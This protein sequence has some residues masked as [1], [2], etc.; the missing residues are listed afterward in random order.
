MVLCQRIGGLAGCAQ[1]H[2]E[3]PIAYHISHL[4]F[5][6]YY[7]L[8]FILTMVVIT[9]IIER[10]EH[11]GGER[12]EYGIPQGT[13]MQGL[14]PFS[15]A[16]YSLGQKRIQP[17]TVWSLCVAQIKASQTWYSGLC[18]FF[19]Q[20]NKNKSGKM[21]GLPLPRESFCPFSDWWDKWLLRGVSGAQASPV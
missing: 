9:T 19:I 15:P 13:G 4:R 14:C 11:E 17:Y 21:K 8:F 12:C 3:S 5:I 7:L 20:R 16:L 10:T 2:P 1:S 6:P 18:A